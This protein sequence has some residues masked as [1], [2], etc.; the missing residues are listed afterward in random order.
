MDIYKI[1]GWIC[2]QF[3]KKRM[4]HFLKEISLS[5][6]TRVLDVGGHPWIWNDSGIKAKI[7]LLNLYDA[8]ELAKQYGGHYEFV[9]ADGTN[10]P[11]G[12]REFEVVFSNSVIEHLGT[13]ERQQKFAAEARR[14]GKKVWVQTPAKCF[15]IEPHLLTP[16]IH[17][18]PRSWRRKLLRYFT[19]WGWMTKPSPLQVEALLDE[20]R[21]L[22]ASEMLKLFPDCKIY[23]ERVLGWTKSYIAIRN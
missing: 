22:T 1:Y 23:R 19:V 7:T 4:K 9:R 2:P 21:L 6:N 17:W 3:R 16:F 11:Y 15:F 13:F 18:L 14:V 20:I 10:L 5:E 12:D 8:S